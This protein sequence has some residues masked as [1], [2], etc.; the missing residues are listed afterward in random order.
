VRALTDAL[1][2]LRCHRNAVWARRKYPVPLD[3]GKRWLLVG[4]DGGALSKSGWHST[5]QRLMR[6]AVE[7]GI[8][9]EQ[10][11]FGLH[12]LMS[13]PF[14]VIFQENFQEIVKFK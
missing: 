10:K 7:A 9:T 6:A 3:P 4:E 2:A 8:I 5:W 14:R 1:D 11:R 13:R 12:G